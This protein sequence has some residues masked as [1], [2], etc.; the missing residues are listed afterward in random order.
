VYINGGGWTYPTIFSIGDAD[1]TVPNFTTLVGSSKVGD[2]LEASPDGGTTILSWSVPR[3]IS[4]RLAHVV[5]VFDSSAGVTAYVDGQSLGTQGTFASSASSSPAWIGNMGSYSNSF[6][7]PTWSGTI[8]E[9]AIYTNALSAATV[10]AHYAMFTYGTNTPPVVLSPP[11]SITIFSGAALNS[12][13]FSVNAEGTLPLSY[14]WKSNNV[15]ISGA[16]NTSL[17]LSNLTLSSSATYSVLVSNPVGST[18][19]AAALAIIAPSGYPAAVIADDPVA[20]WRLGEA[21]GPTALDSWGTND[22]TYFGSEVFGQEGSDFG[23]A[24]TSVD[25]AGNGSSLVKVP[26][27]AGF[28]GG[29]DPNGSWTVEAWVNPDLD[30]ATEGGDF[31]VPIA[32]VD[33]TQD[34]SGYFFLEQSDGWQLRLGNASGYLPGWDGTAGSVGGVPNANAWYHLVGEYDGGAGMGYI[35]INGVR[36]KAASVSGL[37]NNGEATFN[38]GDRGDGAP[39]T[40]RIDE[41]AVYSGILSSN[42]VQAHY[43]AAQP[44]VITVVRQAGAV[45]LTYPV[46]VLYQATKLAGPYT[47]VSGAVS[48][49]SAA[50]TN[51]QMF[52]LL[53]SH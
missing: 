24:N 9:L 27:N 36:V 49:Y 44:P 38:I 52:Y 42:R 33:L 10:N 7:G 43:Y 3:N 20:Y 30:A 47:A 45:L 19:V 39:F 11:S 21:S 40:G 34:R 17:S 37:Q 14:Q 6:T 18:N 13:T 15:V 5:F 25:F 22:G 46:G 48:P 32:S 16:T 31:A 50:T 23:A 1:R 4:D 35:Y 2:A 51:A 12:A 29:L 28:N 53:Q 8:D 26:F 41:V